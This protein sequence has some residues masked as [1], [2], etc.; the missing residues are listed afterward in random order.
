VT[1]VPGDVT[2]PTS[3]AAAM[4]EGVDAVFH[5]A[6]SLTLWRAGHREQMRVNFEGTRHVL[7]AALDRRARR[8]VHVSSILAWGLCAGA[9]TE[10]TPQRGDRAP[11]NYCRSKWLAEREVD[12]AVDAGLDVVVVNPA[13][14][15]GRHDE[16]GFSRIVRIAASRRFRPVPPGGGSFCDAGDVGRALVAAEA[17]GR[18]GERYLLG[19]AD[20]TFLELARLAA[21]LAGRRPPRSALPPVVFHAY[22]RAADW[23]S[24]VTRREPEITPEA[25]TFVT[26]HLTCTS[27]KARRELGYAPRSFEE[28]VGDCYAWLVAAG[29]VPAR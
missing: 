19:G 16:R 21:R 26:A 24:L 6:G 1:V 13:Y 29:H 28:T 14:V 25:A 10:S 20:A 8:V 23:A 2:D 15:I 11:I 17:R 12:R 9:V 3:V 4:P 27:E 5:L 7:A 22:A 18:R